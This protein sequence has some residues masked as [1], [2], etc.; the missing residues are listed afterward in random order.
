MACDSGAIKPLDLSLWKEE[1]KS[2]IIPS[3]VLDETL[4]NARLDV[5]NIHNQ[6]WDLYTH[7]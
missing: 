7:S 2:F 6:E 3:A 4:K 5:R 1:R